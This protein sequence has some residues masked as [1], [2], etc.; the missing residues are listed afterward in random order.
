[1]PTTICLDFLLFPDNTPMPLPFTLANFR[2]SAV[3][4]GMTPFVNVSGAG[5]G[6]QF[7]DQGIKIKLP[8]PSSKVS[9]NI[10][11]F[12]QPIAIRVLSA[13]GAM[14]ANATTNTPNTYTTK[15][16]V[17]RTKAATVILKGG[18]NEGILAKICATM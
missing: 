9:V 3:A 11:Q 5:K 8:F 14:L 2:F 13:T 4:G 10:G 15:T 17:L 1:M 12:A 6:L 18:N 16:F 7:A